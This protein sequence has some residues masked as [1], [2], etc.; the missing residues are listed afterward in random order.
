V[1]AAAT[2]L[3]LGW[4]GW[5]AAVV[6][7]R[8]RPARLVA[9]SAQAQAQA[10]ARAELSARPHAGRRGPPALGGRAVA[11]LGR[12][13]EAL[14]AVGRRLAGRPVDASRDRR[15]G[16]VDV[17]LVLLGAWAGPVPVLVVGGGGAL[18]SMRAR[19]RTRRRAE[20]AVVEGLPELVDLLRVAIDAGCTVPLAVAAVAPL[21]PSP[22]DATLAEVQA[23]TRH[24]A[25]LADALDAL[26]EAHGDAA[27]PLAAALQGSE[28]YGVPLGPTLERVAADVR[29][30]RRQRAEEAARTL[31]VRLVFPLVLCTLPSLV[32]LTIVPAVAGAVRGLRL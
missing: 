26:A 13:L 19:R 27:R 20:A 3:A 30:Q 6:A 4:A 8:H 7:P 16:V 17:A 14:G 32:L 25:R 10:Q 22:F 29:R 15:A 31:P 28:R 1:S 9:W 11:A 21:A 12:P 18:R 24:G 2:A 5:V 23:R